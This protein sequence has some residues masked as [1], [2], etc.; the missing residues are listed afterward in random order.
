M[1][2][3][4]PEISSLMS[5][6]EG[7]QTGNGHKDNQARSNKFRFK[8]GRSSRRERSP[9]SSHKR[10]RRHDESTTQSLRE[11]HH[12]RDKYKRSAYSPVRHN[13]SHEDGDGTGSNASN[14]TDPDVAFQESLFD[15]LAD[16]EGASYWEGVYGQP[17]HIY[18]KV[19]QGPEGELEQMNDEE[20]A[21][22]VRNRMWE[23]S[24]QHIIEERERREEQ[25]RKDRQRREKVRTD[26]DSM[27]EAA[28]Q[29]GERRKKDKS[30]AQAWQEY[31]EKWSRLIE[32]SKDGSASATGTSAKSIIP[33]PVQS[34]RREDIS[35][36]SV[37]AFFQQHP[38]EELPRLLKVERVQWHPDKMQ[39]RLRGEA[40][41]E[42]SARVV[43]AVFQ[44]VDDMWAE[45]RKA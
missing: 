14:F 22:H 11:P 8:E 19:K 24:H 36:T 40:L 42:E 15:A 33:W 10:K 26:F 44:I 16:D 20:Y 35:R 21:A 23:K 2:A 34:G 30:W 41:D 39:Q 18:P 7:K 37:Q 5:E 32:R 12:R 43:T 29:R 4:F 13:F 31:S 6:S 17:I 3:I 27:I 28:L 9:G 1:G 38:P 45:L 25:R